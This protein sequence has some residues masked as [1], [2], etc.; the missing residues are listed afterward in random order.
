MKLSSLT[1]VMRGQMISMKGSVFL[2]SGDN[3]RGP[4]SNDERKIWNGGNE[5]TPKL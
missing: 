1:Y 5:R 2:L 4:N 3:K